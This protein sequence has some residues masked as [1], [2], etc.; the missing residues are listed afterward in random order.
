MF[1]T[2][3]GSGAKKGL[4]SWPRAPP[5]GLA[6]EATAVAETRPAGENHSSE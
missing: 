3:D 2:A 6:R 4:M 1:G 5:K